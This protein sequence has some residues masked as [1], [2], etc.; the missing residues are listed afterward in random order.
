MSNSNITTVSL[1]TH[2]VTSDG[3]DG[4]RT[5]IEIDNKR[6]PIFFTKIERHRVL[7]SGLFGFV[8]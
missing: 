3:I 2:S 8:V 1:L 4:S 6:K 7:L 5:K